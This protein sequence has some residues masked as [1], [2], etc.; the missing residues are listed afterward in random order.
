MLTALLSAGAN[1]HQ[2][3]QQG[4]TLLYKAIFICRLDII[5]LLLQHEPNLE[6]KCVITTTNDGDQ[7]MTPLELAKYLRKTC[8]C[9]ERSRAMIEHKLFAA[10]GMSFS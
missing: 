7:L 9:Q 3:N 1:I 8:L 2:V 10:T 4:I 5:N 6:Q